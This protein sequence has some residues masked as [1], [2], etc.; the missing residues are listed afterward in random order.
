[1]NPQAP[2]RKL[3]SASRLSLLISFVFHALVIATLVY[4][5]A[6]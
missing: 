5:A 4:F 1:M 3:R 6:R 2:K